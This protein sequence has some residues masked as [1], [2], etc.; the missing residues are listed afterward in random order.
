MGELGTGDAGCEGGL[1][2]DPDV[3]D[4]AGAGERQGGGWGGGVD[5]RVGGGVGT[6][7]LNERLD[8]QEKE[9]DN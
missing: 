9:S 3:S 1:V 4:V 8:W 6:V 5:V 2:D 7:V